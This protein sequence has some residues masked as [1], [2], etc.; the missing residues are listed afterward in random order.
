MAG[1]RYRSRRAG[2]LK[3]LA[4]TYVPV[5]MVY[6]RGAEMT[7]LRQ[8]RP[9]GAKAR[10][11]GRWA[12]G[13]F[14]WTVLTLF[15][16]LVA[17]FAYYRLRGPTTEQQTALA[18]LRKD[19]RPAHGVNAFPLLFYLDYD[20]PEDQLDARMAAEIPKVRQWLEADPFSN[21]DYKTDAPLLPRL[22]Q[23]EQAALCGFDGKGCLAKVASHPAAVRATL[24]THSV[25]AERVQAFERTN[26]YWSKFPANPFISIK[27]NPEWARLWLS[28]LALESTSRICVRIGV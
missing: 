4:R 14:G 16:L 25:M 2:S 23:K 1:A 22:S 24:A 11:A 12:L 13:W 8:P 28:A 27:Y 18:L 6:G 10:C 9:H 20:V 7:A 21:I 26:F 17:T 19:Y 5:S 3:Q 15:L